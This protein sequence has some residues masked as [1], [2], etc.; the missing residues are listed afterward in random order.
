MTAIGKLVGRIKV[1]GGATPTAF[2]DATETAVTTLDAIEA[3]LKLREAQAAVL[4]LT[5][6]WPASPSP[7]QQRCSTTPVA[8]LGES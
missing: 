3:K 5:A 4:R 8:P 1:A 7:T 6:S 2:R